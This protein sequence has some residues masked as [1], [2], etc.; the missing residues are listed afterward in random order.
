MKPTAVSIVGA[1]N[2]VPYR[3]RSGVG[4]R[5]QGPGT[6]LLRTMASNVSMCAAADIPVL[7]SIFG[8]RF[9]LYSIFL[10]TYVKFMEVI[11]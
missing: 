10:Y 5:D 8:H 1:V 2:P 11:F 7:A 9:A 4:A 3:L 6:H